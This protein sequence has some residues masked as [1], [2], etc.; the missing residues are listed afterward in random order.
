MA[1][2]IRDTIAQKFLDALNAGI[3]PWRKPWG[4]SSARPRNAITQKPYRGVNAL[5]LGLLANIKGYPTG[6][7][8]TLNQCKKAGGR[9]QGSE[10]KNGTAVV[11]WKF[12][13]REKM[14][15]GQKVEETFP[16]CRSFTVFN[17]AQCEGL[18]LPKET[19]YTNNTIE[20][21]QRIV[22]G[23]PNAP[24]MNIVQSDSAHYTPSTDTVTLPLLSQFVNAESFYA[25]TFH[26]LAHATGHKSR[27]NR[28]GV[29]AGQ[30]FG[31]TSYSKEEL[32]AEMTAAFLSAECGI[33]DQVEQN[34]TAYVQHWAARLNK[35]PRMIIEAAGAAQKA[36]DYILG[37]TFQT[38]DED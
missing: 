32:V 22:D 2:D 23:M 1:N 25:T 4:G 35:E 16:L 8:L 19:S 6:E 34:S 38:D 36:A 11:F 15:N 5:Y 24:V 28:D 30:G 31:S 20:T 18:P 17:R 10:W 13:K 21:A 12:M 29:M 33:L 7:W 26:E 3:I 14:V 37:T 9:V 27:L